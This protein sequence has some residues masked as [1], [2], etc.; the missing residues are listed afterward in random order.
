MVPSSLAHAPLS[1]IVVR[2]SQAT[3]LNS[4][5]F[6]S[7]TELAI[8]NRILRASLV[9]AREE[10]GKGGTMATDLS[11]SATSMEPRPGAI[12]GG[13]RT[14]CGRER[15]QELAARPGCWAR[16]RLRWFVAIATLRDRRLPLPEAA[17]EPR[18]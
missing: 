15:Y 17:E 6:R 8:R 12:P 10:I 3:R 13:I 16:L 1:R 4:S 7:S 14:A 2:I 18:G 11:V 5:R 9:A